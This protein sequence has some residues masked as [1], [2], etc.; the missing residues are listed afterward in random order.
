MRPSRPPSFSS[1]RAGGGAVLLYNMV[2]INN[3]GL[4]EIGHM[5]LIVHRREVGAAAH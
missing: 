3:F 2:A 5:A 4:R 1:A